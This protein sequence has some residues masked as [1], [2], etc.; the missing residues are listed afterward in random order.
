MSHYINDA[1]INCS[2]CEPVCP[3]NA[4]SEGNGVRVI[5]EDTCIDCDACT[6]MCPVDA[7]HI[8]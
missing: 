6:P 1:C 3:V 5:N 7:I 2:S 8:R 4:I